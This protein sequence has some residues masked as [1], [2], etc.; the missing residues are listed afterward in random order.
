MFDDLGDTLDHFSGGLFVLWMPTLLAVAAA[1]VVWSRRRDT[2]G[3]GLALVAAMLLV[4]LV[5][6]LVL[7][8]HFDL[9]RAML[10][11][12]LPEDTEQV[13]ESTSV[14][15]FSMALGVCSLASGVLLVVWLLARRQASTAQRRSRLAIALAL[16]AAVAGCV[17]AI[18]GLVSLTDERFRDDLADAKGTMGS[19]SFLALV[20]SVVA[21]LA[22]MAIARADRRTNVEAGRS[23]APFT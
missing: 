6:L 13:F 18:L 1:C 11:V 12:E 10:D 8:A 3:V 4:A 22:A 17:G 5:S 14:P 21:S 2:S 20:G 16:A 19:A 23:S 15:L 9:H 7:I